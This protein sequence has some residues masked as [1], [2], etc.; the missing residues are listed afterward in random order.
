MWVVGVKMHPS[1]W[2]RRA[3][4]TQIIDI[5][6]YCRAASR[7]SVERMSLALIVRLA[8]LY[9]NRKGF[10]KSNNSVFTPETL[11]PNGTRYLVSAWR[12]LVWDYS[13]ISVK[14]QAKLKKCLPTLIVNVPRKP[15]SY[16]SGHSHSHNSST[17]SNH[18]SKP[19]ENHYGCNWLLELIRRDLVWPASD[20]FVITINAAV[21]PRGVTILQQNFDMMQSH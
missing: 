11:C 7:E 13:S 17:N 6:Q 12:E 21:F 15:R 9:A 5:L 10:C 3:I 19:T 18:C 8:R 20:W 2:V 4:Q 1:C 16:S 14:F